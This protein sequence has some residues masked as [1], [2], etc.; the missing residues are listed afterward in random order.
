MKKIERIL[1]PVDASDCSR[2]AL[3]H[4]LELARHFDARL[5]VLHVYH[6][7][8]YIQPSL[9]VWASV[10][11]RPLWEVAEERAK[12]DLQAFLAELDPADSARLSTGVVLGDPVSCIVEA[13]TNGRHDLVVMGTHGRTGTQRFVL[14]SVA[15][16]IVRLS[17]CPV[18]VIP[19]QGAS[20]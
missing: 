12:H 7:P 9:L 19:H 8:A 3:R 5:E 11:P 1:C 4:A 17:P 2:A 18:L 16:R 14:G 13:V 20:S 15:E 6:V 10:G